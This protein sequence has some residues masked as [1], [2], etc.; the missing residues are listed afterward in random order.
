VVIE[1]AADAASSGTGAP[2]E[3]FR[4][5]YLLSVTPELGAEGL[6]LEP[7]PDVEP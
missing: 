6:L 3:A 7:Q 5:H 2:P 4:G 1:E